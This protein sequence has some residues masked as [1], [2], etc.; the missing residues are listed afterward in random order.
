MET[1]IIIKGTV[2]KKSRFGVLNS[3]FFPIEQ[4]I[5]PKFAMEIH[6]GEKKASF[7]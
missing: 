3:E 5:K 7:A 4:E 2:D 6:L 1:F